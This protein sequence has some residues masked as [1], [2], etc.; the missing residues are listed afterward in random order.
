MLARAFLPKE[1]NMSKQLTL[2]D[3]RIPHWVWPIWARIDPEKRRQVLAVLAGI[4]RSSLTAHQSVKT[5]EAADES[6]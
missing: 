6:K 5:K 3:P 1:T 4:A 2:F